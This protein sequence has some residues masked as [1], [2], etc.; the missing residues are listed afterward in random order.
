MTEAVIVSTA[1]TPLCKSWR[2]ALNMTHGAEKLLSP[3]LV[4]A[5]VDEAGDADD[6]GRPGRRPPPAGGE[7]REEVA[8]S[9]SPDSPIRRPLTP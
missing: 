6:N 5:D 2:G 3:A 4:P 9:R 1:R 7:L 8:S